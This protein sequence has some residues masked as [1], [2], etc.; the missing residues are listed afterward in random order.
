MGEPLFGV[1]L[2]LPSPYIGYPCRTKRWGQ[3]T[4]SER[5]DPTCPLDSEVRGEVI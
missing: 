2:I 3:P 4:L 5:S 1:H